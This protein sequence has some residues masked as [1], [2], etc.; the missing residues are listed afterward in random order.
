MQPGIRQRHPS[1]QPSPATSESPALSSLH[2][3]CSA[4]HRQWPRGT[5]SRRGTRRAAQRSAA[6]SAKCPFCK[7]RLLLAIADGVA[8]AALHAVNAR[9]A[10]MKWDKQHAGRHWGLEAAWWQQ[11]NLLQASPSHSTALEALKPYLQVDMREVSLPGSASWCGI[12][13]TTTD[14]LLP[15]VL[16]LVSYVTPQPGTRHKALHAHAALAHPCRPSWQY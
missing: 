8:P 13:S 11:H 16:L 2:G 10:G 4:T 12:H 9:D 7:M 1:A 5:S 3:A 6:Q 15:C 14:S